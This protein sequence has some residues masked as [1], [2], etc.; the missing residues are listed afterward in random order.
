MT[1]SCEN[2]KK[3]HNT[4]EGLKCFINRGQTGGME[5]SIMKRGGSGGYAA[6]FNRVVKADRPH[7]E[8]DI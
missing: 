4:F 7:R 6:C 5:S 3:S 2:K 1:T 8:V